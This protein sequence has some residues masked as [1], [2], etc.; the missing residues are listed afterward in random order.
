MRFGLKTTENT[1]VFFSLISY[2]SICVIVDQKNY[3]YFTPTGK[4]KWILFREDI[5]LLG[6]AWKP[7]INSKPPRQSAC[8]KLP[9]KYDRA[10]TCR[11]AVVTGAPALRRA[12]LPGASS[13]PGIPWWLKTFHQFHRIN[14]LWKFTYRSMEQ[15]SFLC[16][17][18]ITFS[19]QF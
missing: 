14:R 6:L 8:R 12:S 16:T 13:S 3:N 9:Y 10:P 2:Y 7:L 19:C 15:Y 11:G 1:F 4:T 17:W 5:C 18:S